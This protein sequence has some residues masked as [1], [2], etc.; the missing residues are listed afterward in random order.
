MKPSVDSPTTRGLLW[1]RV[2]E[3]SL[4]V[5]PRPQGEG[6]QAW[7]RGRSVDL[8][9]PA[10]GHAFTPTP[11]DL[12]VSAIASNLAWSAR[13][14]LARRALGDDVTVSARWSTQGSSLGDVDVYVQVTVAN[15]NEVQ[16]DALQQQLEAAVPAHLGRRQIELVLDFDQLATRPTSQTE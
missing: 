14:F 15:V 11:D 5:L 13:S 12:L 2:V 1:D 6:L 9:D 10:R 7:I 4:V 8:A 16:R 3:A